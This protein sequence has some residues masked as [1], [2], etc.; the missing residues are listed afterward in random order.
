[1]RSY[2]GANLAI[3][4]LLRISRNLN[5]LFYLNTSGITGISLLLDSSTCMISTRSEM[6]IIIAKTN[7]NS[8]M[9][10]SIVQTI[11]TF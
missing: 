7:H 4:S 2:I 5:S 3:P 1:M 6:V 11:L 10:S 9:M 8:D